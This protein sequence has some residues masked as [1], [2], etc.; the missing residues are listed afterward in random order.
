MT[1]T[2]R[3]RRRPDKTMGWTAAK[4]LIFA[5]FVSLGIAANIAWKPVVNPG[6]QDCGSSITFFLES[7]EN[8]LLHPGEPGAPPNAVALASQPTCRDRAYVEIEKAGLS[9]AT[10]FGLTL[11]GVIL[12][13]LDDRIAYWTAPR[14]ES[15][16]RDMPRQSRIAHGLIPNVDVDEL[17]VELPPLES[18]EI[19]A[20]LFFGAVAFAAL[21]YVGP[22]DA[23]RSE[24]GDLSLGFVFAGM[25]VA[26]ASFVAAAVQRKAVFPDDEPWPTTI[27]VVM[28][29][30]W[31]GRL[32]PIVGTFGT[33]IHHLRKTGLD[34][35]TA[36]LDVQVLQTVSALMH[37]GLLVLATLLVLGDPL[38]S[39]RF[40]REQLV[41]AGVLGLFFL[42]GVSRSV[43]RWRALPVRP[44]LVAIWRLW[45][46][47]PTPR[48]VALLFGG[49]LLVT[50]T[51]VAVLGLSL[52][53]FGASVTVGQLLFVSLVAVVAGALSPTPNG[54]G[55]VEAA[56]V[57]L[58]FRMGVDP[59]AAVCA[60]L[61]FRT[62]TFWLP[63]FPGLRAARRMKAIGAL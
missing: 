55:V 51:N 47:A 9:V 18:P 46:V 30:A 2:V 19:Y 6:V 26:V 40:E 31:V 42:S 1:V 28:A 37:G 41:L 5:G 25:L 59:A 3:T 20:L 38:P 23:V 16:L 58:L 17:G 29:S 53:A 33:D 50:V 60:S 14:F 63:M 48:K 56:I 4:I 52:G 27:E 62:L 36:V 43:K 35:G 11:L 15:L 8:V 22:L 39:V 32:R 10:F 49:T 24:L 57:L 54:V 7:R 44:N 45:R 13:L 34:R 61:T 12:G 21:P